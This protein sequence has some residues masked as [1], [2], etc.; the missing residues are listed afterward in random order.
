MSHCLFF[1][2]KPTDPSTESWIPGRGV[3]NGLGMKK[4]GQNWKAMS[5]EEKATYA[6]PKPPNNNAG[7]TRSSSP[8]YTSPESETSAVMTDDASAGRAQSQSFAQ[9]R[10]RVDRWMDDWQRDVSAF[11]IFHSMT[12]TH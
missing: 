4:V 7:L 9:S 12:F 2:F 11:I 6:P 3:K 1:S 8:T 10:I 5:Q